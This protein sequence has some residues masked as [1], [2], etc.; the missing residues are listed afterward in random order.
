MVPGS[1]TAG[2]FSSGSPNS[3]ATVLMSMPRV[4][5]L[6]GAVLGVLTAVA[7]EPALVAVGAGSGALADVVAVTAAGAAAETGA[8]AGVALAAGAALVA[9]EEAG[10]VSV[11]ALAAMDAAAGAVPVA[12][13]E[14]AEMDVA[15]GAEVSV[16]A[17]VLPAP[18][19]G[20]FTVAIWPFGKMTVFGW[21]VDEH[22]AKPA[23]ASTPSARALSRGHFI[24]QSPHDLAANY[25]TKSRRKSLLRH[26]LSWLS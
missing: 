6:I 16:G 14:A 18:G 21:M 12:A 8:G 13:L 24:G 1:G 15:A 10:A 26:W 23:P 4:G 17:A 2:S 19:A 11:A 9:L 5:M 22:A 25:S 7:A 3:R 20:V